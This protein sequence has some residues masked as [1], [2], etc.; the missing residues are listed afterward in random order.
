MVT[1]QVHHIAFIFDQQHGV[2]HGASLNK[3]LTTCKGTNATKRSG[4]RLVVQKK[5]LKTEPR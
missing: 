5:Q 1:Q 2:I 4:H 3:C